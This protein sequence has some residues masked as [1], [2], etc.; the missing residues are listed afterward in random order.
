MEDKYVIINSKIPYVPISLID[1]FYNSQMIIAPLSKI[2]QIIQDLT[3][4]Y[5]N[6]EYYAVPFEEYMQKNSK[7]K[8]IFDTPEYKKIMEELEKII[9]DCAKDKDKGINGL[10]LPL[11]CEKN[12]DYEICVRDAFDKLLTELEKP[13]LHFLQSDIARICNI[14][15][16]AFKAIS[17]GDTKMCDDMMKELLNDYLDDPFYVSELDKSYAFRGTSC[18]ENLQVEGYDKMYNQMKN[19]QLS[20]FRGR[21]IKSNNGNQNIEHRSEMVHLPYSMLDKSSNLRFSEKGR[22]GLYLGVT[23]WV[24]AKECR[25]DANTEDLY[26]SGF[27]FNEKGKKLKILNLCVSQSLINGISNPYEDNAMHMKML[28]IFPLV[29]ATSVAIKEKDRDIKYEYLLSQSLMR[30]INLK[31]IDGIAYLSRQGKDDFDFP[32]TVSLAFPINDIN[33]QQQYGDL[34]NCFEMTEPV[35]IKA[36]LASKTEKKSYILRNYPR[37]N[38]INGIHKY[39]NFSSKVYEN[40]EMIFYQDT[41]YS[42]ID[43]YIEQQLYTPYYINKSK[44]KK[45]E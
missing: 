2:E 8:N 7:I 30:V 40:E 9:S 44:A 31:G 12:C 6:E 1:N 13:A 5:P 26:V 43:E 33:D 42:T 24:C 34:C 28:R 21:T 19:D 25:W 3:I 41:I 10:T 15:I 39:E 38:T 17:Q 36:T 22:V 14:I 18:F 32:H 45:H 27:H 29:I 16:D 11:T 23:S 35:K 20:F 37:Y 4:Q